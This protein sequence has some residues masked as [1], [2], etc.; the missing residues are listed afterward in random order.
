MTEDDSVPTGRPHG[1]IEL[2]PHE[3]K[4]ARDYEEAEEH[5]ALTETEEFLEE[6]ELHMPGGRCVRCGRVIEPDE[7]VRRTASGG[8]EHEFCQAGIEPQPGA[9][10]PTGG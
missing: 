5:V 7:D 1:G 8:Y 4:T 10:A 9:P 6:N 2:P 3:V